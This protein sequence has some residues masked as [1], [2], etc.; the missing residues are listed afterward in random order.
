M[1]PEGRISWTDVRRGRNG[2]RYGPSAPGAPPALSRSGPAPARAVRPAARPRREPRRRPPVPSPPRARRWTR[3][4]GRRND[5]RARCRSGAD[6]SGQQPESVGQMGQRPEGV[7][8]GALGPA[9]GAGADAAQQGPAPVR[10]PRQPVHA[11]DPPDRERVRRVAAAHVHHVLGERE[12]PLTPPPRSGT[13]PGAALQAFDVAVEAFQEGGEAGDVLG[14]QCSITRSRPA[15]FEAR[16]ASR[17][18]SPS[19]VMRNLRAMPPSGSGMRSTTPARSIAA[20]CRL[21]VEA[22]RPKASLS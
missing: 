6:R 9:V 1:A 4:P 14:D 7:G 21:R 16:S 8:V 10:L 17:R 18:R 11:V 12:R 22:S 5:G 15:M 3:R 20:V 2:R 13:R 19:S